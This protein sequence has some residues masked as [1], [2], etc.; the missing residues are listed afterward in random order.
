MAETSLRPHFV[1]INRVCLRASSAHSQVRF[2]ISRRRKSEKGARKHL[3]LIG[4]GRVPVLAR[5]V[6]LTKTGN[7]DYET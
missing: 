4:I 5:S 3:I 7:I 6:L 2:G 1:L